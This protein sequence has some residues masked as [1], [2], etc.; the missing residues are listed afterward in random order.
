M[1]GQ[2][3]RPLATVHVLILVV[4]LGVGLRLWA[5]ST[6][7]AAPIGDSAD[8]D[9]LACRL[10]NG[11]GFVSGEGRATA[12]RPPGYPVFVAGIYSVAGC[13]PR[14]AYAV[15]AFL[16]GLT[17]ALVFSLGRAAIG[18]TEGLVG[19]ALAAVY[20]GLV[21][22]PRVLLSENL[23]LPFLIL[24]CLAIVPRDRSRSPGWGATAGASLALAIL[25]R[26]AALFL[27]PLV[28]I[29]YF[30]RGGRLDG[31][32]ARTL[33]ALLACLLAGVAP[34]LYRNYR[35]FG[36][37]PVLTTQVGITLYASYW[38]PRVAGKPIWGDLPGREDP[39]VAEAYSLPTELDASS[40]LVAATMAGLRKDPILALRLL[41]RKL[42][43][44]LAP[45]DWE[46]FP[47]ASGDSRRLN[48]GYLLV[49]PPSL[50]GVWLLLRRAH[51]TLWILPASVLL[52]A[53]V[54][55]GSPRF[56]L[57][58]EPV[59]ILAAA[60]GLTGFAHSKPA[61]GARVA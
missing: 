10:A 50:L 53:V 54:F 1:S 46:W 36:R 19:A 9:D 23:V 2:P 42:S 18:P 49:I 38:P 14:H 28:V 60:A 6:H 39:R 17:V 45:F 4:A 8:Y 33:A 57:P 44:L 52:Q 48:V 13:E 32:R 51:W 61:H 35:V 24:P 3:T 12:W 58:A 26:P 34:W 15:Q 30:E 55:Y 59:L 16:G 31:A 11:H 47:K 21:W 43:G 40:D 22:L 7:P 41:P 27:L 25:T 29:R 5:V 37:F 20:P 56:R